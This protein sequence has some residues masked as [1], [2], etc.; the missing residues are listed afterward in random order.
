MKK[1]KTKALSVL[2]VST[3][4]F[5]L[6]A[7]SGDADGA[8]STG[9]ASSSSDSGSSDSSVSAKYTAD[10]IKD[11]TEAEARADSE[12]MSALAFEALNRFDG[13]VSS[14][15]IAIAAMGA[16]ADNE[17]GV[18]VVLKQIYGTGLDDAK[19]PEA[20]AKLA[21]DYDSEV[22]DY[23][24]DN[25]DF[26]T[27]LGLYV[28]DIAD[29]TSPKGAVDKAVTKG[30]SYSAA[31]KAVEIFSDEFQAGADYLVAYEV[32]NSMF[33]NGYDL[34]EFTSDMTKELLADG[35]TQAQIDSSLSRVTC[36]DETCYGLLFD[37]VPSSPILYEREN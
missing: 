17:D 23:V 1:F 33:S 14:K 2:A 30:F 28:K 9:S 34:D 37:G 8:D 20:V 19:G 22:S 36:T 32:S 5:G 10:T 15:L 24:A 18:K 16:G 12:G 29:V 35:F 11:A 6:A 3:L 27:M 25:V 26:S 7:C 31:E 21:S 4:M 13:H